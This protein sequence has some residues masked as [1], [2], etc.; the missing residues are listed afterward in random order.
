M[1]VRECQ[2]K[3]K[4]LFGAIQLCSCYFDLDHHFKTKSI[5][6]LLQILFAKISYST[7]L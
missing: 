2:A 4:P 1:F 7:M 5:V 6:L 3:V